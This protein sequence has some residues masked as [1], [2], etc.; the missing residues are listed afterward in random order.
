MYSTL[1]KPPEF[2]ELVTDA[3]SEALTLEEVKLH[4]RVT[5]SADDDAISRDITAARLF[6]QKETGRAIMSSTWR[7]TMDWFPGC[8]FL[9]Y[10]PVSAI[11]SIT[12][13]DTAGTS[14]TLSASDYTSDLRSEKARITPAYGL[15]WP[16]TQSRIGAVTVNYTAGYASAALVPTPIKQA[17]L[18]LCDHWYNQRAAAATGNVKQVDFSVDALLAGYMVAEYA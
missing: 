6:V 8:I 14:Q 13:Y 16:S 1:N 18:M 11:T 17:M 5:D 4:S 2:T 9:R 7:R 3:T 12:Y 10:P 15:T